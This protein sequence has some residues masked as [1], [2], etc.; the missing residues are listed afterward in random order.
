MST[1]QIRVDEQ[2]KKDAYQAFEKLNLSPSDALRLFL[3]YVAENEK[4]PFSEVSVVVSESDDDD[5]ILAVVRE[6]LKKPAKRIR[7]NV[8]DL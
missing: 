2:L 6:R 4:L 3:R 5:A 8:D 7:V 1:I